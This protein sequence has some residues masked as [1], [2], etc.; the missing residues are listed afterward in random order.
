MHARCLFYRSSIALAL[1]LAH[2]AAAGPFTRTKLGDDST[3]GGPPPEPAS[4]FNDG[5][6]KE[7]VSEL[8][9]G[10]ARFELAGAL[11]LGVPMGDYGS[12]VGT[13]FGFSAYGGYV[14]H[15]APLVRIAIGPAL[16]YQSYGAKGGGG[17]AGLFDIT[18]KVR[19]EYYVPAVPGLALFGDLGLGL[20]MF[21][22]STD[23][24]GGETQT[25]VG[26]FQLG[27]GAA[28]PILPSFALTGELA[29]ERTPTSG[30]AAGRI[31]LAIGGSYAY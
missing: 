14:L 24:G 12:A 21:M 10:D 4:S 16:A 17:S 13:G 23:F 18:A 19:G 3:G 30:D 2:A 22:V 5:D 8:I 26:A 15:P 31:S 27:A 29:Y 20:G 25:N 9:A 28:F 11:V 1:C 6:L 7:G